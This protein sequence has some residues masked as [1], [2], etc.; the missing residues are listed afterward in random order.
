[1]KTILPNSLR[2]LFLVP[3]VLLTGACQNIS[4]LDA[5]NLQRPAFDFK[6]TGARALE[7]GLVS[8]IETGRSG[9]AGVAAGGCA[10][11]Q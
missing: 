11:C 9:G 3:A 2:F 6:A 10:F 7:G 4:I 8:Q 1:M 5:G